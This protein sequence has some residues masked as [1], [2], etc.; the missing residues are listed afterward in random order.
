MADEIVVE[1]SGSPGDTPDGDPMPYPVV[2]P[3]GRARGAQALSI[4]LGIAGAAMAAGGSSGSTSESFLQLGHAAVAR[5][6]MFFGFGAVPGS[7]RWG[8]I[9]MVASVGVNIYSYWLYS[10]YGATLKRRA[11]MVKGA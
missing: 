11:V 1:G 5:A 2:D 9:L 8:I 3:T 7:L 4:G 10:Q 6:A